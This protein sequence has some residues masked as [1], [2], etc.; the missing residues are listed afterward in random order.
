[1]N[2]AKSDWV[3]E[4]HDAALQRELIDGWASAATELEPARAE[5]IEA[6]RQRRQAH[7]SADIAPH[8]RSRRCGR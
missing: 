2:R 8:R 4:P 6:W 1:M 3:L 7:V 5:Q